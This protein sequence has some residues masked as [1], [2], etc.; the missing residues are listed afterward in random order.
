MHTMSSR[1]RERSER[2]SGSRLLPVC[3]LLS[4]AAPAFLTA[5]APARQPAEPPRVTLI[6]PER[7]WDG[8]D[9]PPHDGW[10]VLVRGDRIDAVGP[11]AQ[12]SAPAGAE[13]VNLPGTTLIPGLIEAHS[14]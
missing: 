1:N 4:I 12:V 10:A 6:V 11:R 9:A 13:T 14:H 8:T 7:V 2:V 5:Q 3:G